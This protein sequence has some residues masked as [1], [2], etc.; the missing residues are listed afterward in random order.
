MPWLIPLLRL[1]C[2]LAGVAADPAEPLGQ[3]R[4]I[5]A[6][7]AAAGWAEVS[8]T[9]VDHEALAVALLIAHPQAELKSVLG[10]AGDLIT[11][12]RADAE[13]WGRQ[14]GL[15]WPRPQP[16]RCRQQRQEQ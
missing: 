15:R 3:G 1:P 10:T 14:E 13:P 8:V 7:N 16:Q 2:Q 12:N 11:T 9:A 6:L 5:A 4:H